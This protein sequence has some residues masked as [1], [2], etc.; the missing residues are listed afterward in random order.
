ML[1][2]INSIEFA[3]LIAYGALDALF[4]VDF[5]RFFFLARNCL[6]GAF[7]EANPATGAVVRVNLVIEESLADAC[8]AFLFVDVGF[9]LVSK[10]S[11]RAQNRVSRSAAECTQ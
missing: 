11:K 7:P 6:M 5:V 3:G 9:I 10:I 4:L 8:G 2:D 1:F